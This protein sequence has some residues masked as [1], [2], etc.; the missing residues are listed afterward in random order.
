MSAAPTVAGVAYFTPG[1]KPLLERLASFTQSASVENR[2]MIMS[3]GPDETAFAAARDSLQFASIG[4]DGWPYIH[5][6]RGP[7]GFLRT[8]GE[9]TLGLPS[10]LSRRRNISAGT[11]LLFLMDCSS[12]K[13]LKIWA[14]SE[15]SDDPA[16]IA[17]LT[18]GN[19]PSSIQLAFL[20]HV[21]AFQWNCWSY[22]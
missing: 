1:I 7:R 18:D 6:Y 4:E 12:R 10:P 21:R 5:H 16:T 2:S 20:F 11:T 19:C 15:I 13:R 22:H 9:N 8:L 14:D 17:K 3:I